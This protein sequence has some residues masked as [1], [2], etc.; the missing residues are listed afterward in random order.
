MDIEFSVY[1][2]ACEY[3][4][5][6]SYPHVLILGFVWVFT[7]VV[8]R[9]CVDISTCGSFFSF[10]FVCVDKVKIKVKGGDG[11]DGCVSFYRAKYVCVLAMVIVDSEDCGYM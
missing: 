2:C 1:I 8:I 11:G 6:C 7:R 3:W 5:L 4:D 10:F 9:L